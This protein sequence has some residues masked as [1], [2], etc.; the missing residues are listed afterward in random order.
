MATELDSGGGGQAG[1]PTLTQQEWD[2]M[3]AAGGV[4]PA[5]YGYVLAPP[6]ANTYSVPNPDG[7]GYVEGGIPADP[8]ANITE[9]DLNASA[10]GPH[11]PNQIMPNGQP[12][13]DNFKVQQGADGMFYYVD[14]L[15]T[16]HGLVPGQ[17]ARSSSTSTRPNV[18]TSY[19][20]AGPSWYEQ[21]KIALDKRAQDLAEAQHA[22]ANAL[23]Q[24]QHEAQ[25]RASEAQAIEKFNSDYRTYQEKSPYGAQYGPTYFSPAGSVFAQRAPE[26]SVLKDAFKNSGLEDPWASTGAVPAG[27]TGVSYMNPQHPGYVDWGHPT[28]QQAQ[29]QQPAQAGSAPEPNAAMP[30]IDQIQQWHDIAHQLPQPQQTQP[31]QLGPTGPATQLPS[32][33]D[34]GTV[35]GATGAPQL[36]VAHGGEEVIPN[37]SPDGMGGGDWQSMF[38]TWHDAIHQSPGTPQPFASGSQAGTGT[39]NIQNAYGQSVNSQ[40]IHGSG[41]DVLNGGMGFNPDTQQYLNNHVQYGPELTGLSGYGGLITP[42]GTPV[43]MSEWQRKQFDPTSIA[44]YGDYAHTIAGWNANDL[45]FQSDKITGNVGDATLPKNWAPIGIQPSPSG[46]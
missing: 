20:P 32:F 28:V 34:G 45:A 4:D 6:D 11:G 2:Y 39:G 36:V 41:E 18:P 15:G 43:V 14:P 31:V 7:L 23:A 40:T 27:Y 42:N 10:A 24:K 5:D 22:S 44:N 37:Q 46:G 16:P 12:A 3:Q 38:N 9:A 35:P 17:T 1:A 8:Y 13:P 30:N 19:G 29:P 26:S 25:Q 21:Q 33:K